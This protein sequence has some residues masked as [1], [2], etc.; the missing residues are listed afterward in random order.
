MWALMSAL[1]AAS[2]VGVVAIERQ[3]ATAPATQSAAAR[4]LDVGQVFMAYRNAVITYAENNPQFGSA[5]GQSVSIGLLS[6]P[7][8]SNSQS[9]TG[10]ANLT[11]SG[12]GGARTVYVWGSDTPGEAAGLVASLGGDWSIGR[13]TAAGWSTPAAGLM[14]A[15]PASL[16]SD[17]PVGDIISVVQIG[18][19]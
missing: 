5:G 3:Q 6:L 9:M 8:G 12:S 16:Q 10:L 13:V 11:V 1:L 4:P 15:L 17:A 19:S 18:G 7:A 14:G 2:L